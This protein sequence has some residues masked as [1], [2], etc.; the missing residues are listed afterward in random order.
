M[1]D[2]EVVAVAKMKTETFTSNL[3]H[4]YSK[5]YIVALFVFPLEIFGVGCTSPCWYF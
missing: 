3:S 5:C 1:C 4:G 2:F